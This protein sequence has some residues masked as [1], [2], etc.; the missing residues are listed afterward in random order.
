MKFLMKRMA[1]LVVMIMMTF[2]SACAQELSQVEK[3]FDEMVKKY[4]NIEGVECVSVVKG[5]GLEMMKMLLNKEL[6]KSFMKGV[7]SITVIDYSDASQETCSALHHDLDVFTSMFEE[8]DVS[9]EPSFSDND[10]LRS[11][12]SVS[13][14][15]TVSDFIIAM[16][17]EDSKSIMY[18][19]GEIKVE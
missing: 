15:G 3:M 12:A 13:D 16:E 2:A 18:M 9:E 8:F 1:L 4:E 7:T 14:D 5:G 10:Y 17:N 19:A 6:G 11:F